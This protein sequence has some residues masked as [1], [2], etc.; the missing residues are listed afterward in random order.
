MNS[1]TYN[2]VVTRDPKVTATLFYDKFG[3]TSFTERFASLTEQDKTEALIVSPHRNNNFISFEIDF[4]EAQQTRYAV[5]KMVE[6]EQLLEYFLVSRTGAEELIKLKAG[7]VKALRGAGGL[8]DKA[9]A[10]KPS[11][12]VSYG[13]GDDISQW[14]GPYVVELI[15]ANL[16]TT[17]DGVRE[18]EFMF[19]PTVQGQLALTNKVFDDTGVAQK[20]SIFNSQ[21]NLNERFKALTYKEYPLLSKPE[22]TYRVG[23]RAGINRDVESKKSI[24]GVRRPDDNGEEALGGFDYAVRDLCKTYLSDLFRIPK[25]N[26]LFLLDDSFSKYDSDP[27]EINKNLAKLA[28]DMLRYGIDVHRAIDF[29]VVDVEPIPQRN[30]LIKQ[31][32]LEQ[33]KNSNDQIKKLKKQIREES[34]KVLSE[35]R[36]IE[37]RANSERLSVEEAA[38]KFVDGSLI[39]TRAGSRL[40]PQDLI[41]LDPNSLRFR[42]Q[43]RDEG[44]RAIASEGAIIIK[45]LLEKIEKLEDKVD[46]TS[47]KRA[48]ATEEDKK[49][50]ILRQKRFQ[51]N[52]DGIIESVVK[53]KDFLGM[54][55]GR[56]VAP[57]DTSDTDLNLL[58]PLYKLIQGI[59]KIPEGSPRPNDFTLIEENDHKILKLLEKHRLI[60][61]ADRPVLIFG[62]ENIIHTMIYPDAADTMDYDLKTVLHEMVDP[63]ATVGEVANLVPDLTYSVPGVVGGKDPNT[64]AGAHA[65]I[66][67]RV[68]DYRKDFI[69]TFVD[70]SRPLTSSFNEP[71]DFGS[72]YN[73]AITQIDS[74]KY[75]LVFTYNT[76]NSN[77]LELSFDSSPYKA[78]LLDIGYESGY[79][80]LDESLTVDQIIKDNSVFTPRLVELIKRI[81]KEKRRYNQKPE[82]FLTKLKNSDVRNLVLEILADSDTSGLGGTDTASLLDFVFFKTAGKPSLTKVVDP[83]ATMTN[84]VDVL[85]NIN[86]YIINVNLKTLPFFNATT[87]LGRDCYLFGLANNIIGSTRL[88]DIDTPAFYTGTYTIIGYKHRIG[89]D[90]AYSEFQL[91]PNSVGSGLVSKNINVAEFFNI[92]KEE[93]LGFEKKKKEEVINETVATSNVPGA[94]GIYAIAIPLRN[95]FNRLFGGGG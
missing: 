32:M 21:I 56:S 93:I 91:V 43:Y 48:A 62:R 12:Y 90:Q 47:A 51:S 40:T 80:L 3:R 87:V 49:N 44:R 25:N 82:E 11:F 4:P 57:A 30:N 53:L 92:T 81:E 65:E 85:R 9:K 70:L 31:R 69:T 20:G 76:K 22:E 54:T 42:T 73:E 5:L 13:M 88:R 19:S 50:D 18:C 2:I 68:N 83:S 23:L 95:L 78:V 24:F 67:N 46:E 63:F 16:T 45:D 52:P 66:I 55:F 74:L 6:S 15:D 86:K 37:I 35:N 64:A 27:Y 60:D 33:I 36:T 77:V 8:I 7:I 10:I 59:I 17:A 1:N 61:D 28:S 39:I 34:I 26:V 29:D 71:L 75:P 79:K 58:Y 89:P 41:F 84:E 94:T 72:Y 38:A 14:S